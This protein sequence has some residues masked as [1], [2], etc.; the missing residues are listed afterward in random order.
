MPKLDAALDHGYQVFNLTISR[1]QPASSCRSRRSTPGAG[2]SASARAWLAWWRPGNNGLERPFWPAQAFPGMIAV[3]ALAADGRSRASFS[4]YGSLGGR[5]RSRP[6]PGQ[7]VGDR[8]LPHL[9]SAAG[10]P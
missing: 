10:R 8:A 6:R 1:V 4:N 5:I 3:G 9:R 7:R 2:G